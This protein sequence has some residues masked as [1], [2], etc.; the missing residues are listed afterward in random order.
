M[1]VARKHS[2]SQ[3]RFRDDTANKEMG[4][5]QAPHFVL[6]HVAFRRRARAA[7]VVAGAM[8]TGM[9]IVRSGSAGRG[10]RTV[11]AGLRRRFSRCSLHRR[12]KN[13]RRQK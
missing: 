9:A 12:G 7:M 1:R 11:I 13:R 10:T 8:F 6:G 3:R 2:R 5:R 4:S